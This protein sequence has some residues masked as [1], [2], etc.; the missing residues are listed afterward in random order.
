MNLISWSPFR[1]FDG[2]FDRYAR[3][4]SVPRGALLGRD[5]EWKPA[6]SITESDKEYTIKA[7]L[8]EVKN[9]DIDVKLDNGVLTIKGERHLEKSSEDEVEHR[10]ESF[11]GSFS[12]S[13]SLPEDVDATAISAKSK[14]GVLTVRLP[15]AKENRPESLS[16]EVS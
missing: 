12:R 7:D 3:D 5:A 13:F 1:E 8:P 4:L 14:D 2:L 10:R 9:E 11:Y 15:K 16:I 6:A